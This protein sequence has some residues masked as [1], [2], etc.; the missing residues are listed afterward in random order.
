LVFVCELLKLFVR[1]VFNVDLAL[2]VSSTVTGVA[3]ASLFCV[4]W[5][6]KTTKEVMP[7]VPVLIVSCH[8][9]E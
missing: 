4:F 6:K 8:V 5:I 7:V 2:M 9:S 3:R 1:E